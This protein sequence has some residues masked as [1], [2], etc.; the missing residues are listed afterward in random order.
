MAPQN[1]LTESEMGA[2]LFRIGMGVIG[3][4]LCLGVKDA[5]KSL[6]LVP[7][8]KVLTEQL[9]KQQSEILRRLNDLE[10]K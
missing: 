8:L 1:G 2:W 5:K 6:D 9:E 7:G 3:F 10:K 4:F